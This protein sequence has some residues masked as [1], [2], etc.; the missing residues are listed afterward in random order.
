MDAKVE[1]IPKEKMSETV[2]R[3]YDFKFK[4]ASL[5]AKILIRL[6]V[7]STWVERSSCHKKDNEDYYY[8]VRF[9]KLHPLFWVGFISGLLGYAF[10]GFLKSFFEYFRIEFWKNKKTVI[11]LLER[12]NYLRK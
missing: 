7:I 1:I 10:Y 12:E 6:G 4:R 11:Q 9:N 8:C 3:V 2:K 5:L